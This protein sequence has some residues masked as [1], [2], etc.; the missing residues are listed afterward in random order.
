MRVVYYESI[1][2]KVKRRP[3]YACRCDERLKNYNWGIYTSRIHWV[4]RGTGTHLKIEMRS[5]DERFPSEEW[6]ELTPWWWWF[7]YS[8]RKKGE[9]QG[10]NVTLDYDGLHSKRIKLSTWHIMCRLGRSLRKW[11]QWLI[12]KGRHSTRIKKLVVNCLLWIDKARAKDKM[13]IWV[14]MRWKTTN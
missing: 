8:R 2:W 13:Y 10:K 14:S 5:I 6:F 4:A 7:Y 1:K 11:D 9:S 3:I 12:K